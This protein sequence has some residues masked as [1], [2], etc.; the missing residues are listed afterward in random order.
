MVGS[1]V[2]KGLKRRRS[3]LDLAFLGPRGV[4]FRLVHPVDEEKA[5]RAMRRAFATGADDTVHVV[6]EVGMMIRVGLRQLTME[7]TGAADVGLKEADVEDV[8]DAKCVG[9]LELVGRRAEL[10]DDAERSCPARA[11]LAHACHNGEIGRGEEDRVA[12]VEVAVDAVFVGL[13][14]LVVFCLRNRSAGGLHPFRQEVCEAVG[15][16]CRVVAVRADDG[17]EG[18]WRLRAVYHEKRRLF[19]G[20]LDRGV[21]CELCG[22][23][24]IVP[25][26]V[27][28]AE[29]GAEDLFEC[30]VGTLR[31]AVCLRVERRREAAF[32]ARQ[33]P[34]V[35][36][37]G[38]DK[39]GVT[40][41]NQHGRGAVEADDFAEEDAGEAWGCDGCGGGCK[42]RHF[43]KDVDEDD[44][45][46]MATFGT[47]QLCDQVQR[48]GV[49]G[50]RGDGEWL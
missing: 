27:V 31:L 25:I 50:T 34:Q 43:A 32:R 36:P 18:V 24:M 23:E 47:W 17:I 33:A 6:A 26:G 46:I 44:N 19:G 35:A 29:V 38:A 20:V 1:F 8:V 13:G 48:D 42:V 2:P 49:K 10:L 21:V 11:K 37:E 16:R 39:A 7:P 22:V 15:S 41:R 9:Q 45:G 28:G 3:V 30:A 4:V 40:V 14:L 5:L 12:D